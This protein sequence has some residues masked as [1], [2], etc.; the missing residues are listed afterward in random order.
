M[1]V[2]S[3]VCCK[4]KR[5]KVSQGIKCHSSK[6]KRYFWIVRFDTINPHTIVMCKHTVNRVELVGWVGAEPEQ[7][8]IPSGVAVCTF[9]VAT[10][11]FAGRD[12]AGE[13]LVEAEWTAVEAWE[14]RETGQKRFKTVVPADEV[15]FPDARERSQDEAGTVEET[16]EGLSF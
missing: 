16:A 4:D 11:R 5:R 9:R 10:N 14:D 13:R 6:Q 1:A 3:Q 15:L 8:F 12:E 7:R 2:G